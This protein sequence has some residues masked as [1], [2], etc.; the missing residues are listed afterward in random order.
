LVDFLVQILMDFWKQEYESMEGGR[1][2]RD[3]LG[4]GWLA[5]VWV[6]VVGVGGL[7]MHSPKPSSDLV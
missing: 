4:G 1:S 5:G 2:M 3:V 7:L 6:W